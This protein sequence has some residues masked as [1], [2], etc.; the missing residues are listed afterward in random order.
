MTLVPE[1]QNGDTWK[2]QIVKFSLNG[3]DV[4]RI[5]QRVI[6]IAE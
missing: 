3:F 5:I 2:K 4:R 6:Q 1:V